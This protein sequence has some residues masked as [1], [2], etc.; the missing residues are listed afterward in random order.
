[1]AT[2]HISR[3]VRQRAYSKAC[4]RIEIYREAINDVLGLI[5]DKADK[6]RVRRLLL[7][8]EQQ[9]EDYICAI[10]DG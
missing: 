7:K 3:R 10:P 9:I 1:M 8:K 2:P 5:Q 6:R 4:V